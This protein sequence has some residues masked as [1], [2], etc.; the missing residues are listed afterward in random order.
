LASKERES[1]AAKQLKVGEETLAARLSREERLVRKIE[2]GSEA[3]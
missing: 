2:M 3:A 1:C